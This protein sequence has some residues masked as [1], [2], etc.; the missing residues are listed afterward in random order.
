MKIIASTIDEK[1]RELNVNPLTGL[2]SSQ[3]QEHRQKYGANVVELPA[4]EPWWK[5]LLEKFTE[6]PIPILIV[7]AVISMILAIFFKHEFPV[8]GLAILAAVSLAVGVG[9]INE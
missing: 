1:L 2:S 4:P 8:E 9:F 7:A 6:N 5:N 3:V